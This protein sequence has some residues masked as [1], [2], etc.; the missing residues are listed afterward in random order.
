MYHKF[1]KKHFQTIAKVESRYLHTPEAAKILYLSCCS[2]TTSYTATS[3][4]VQVSGRLRAGKCVL[5]ILFMIAS[6]LTCHKL[7]QIAKHQ[8]RAIK[9]LLRRRH[10]LKVIASRYIV[11]LHRNSFIVWCA[12]L[13]NQ[14]VL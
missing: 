6:P 1:A 2:S 12:S 7:L 9:Q 11:E 13:D 14:I 4:H 10:L 5:N 3:A 8:I